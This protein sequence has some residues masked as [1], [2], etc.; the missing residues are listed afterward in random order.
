MPPSAAAFPQLNPFLRGNWV[1]LPSLSG[2]RVGDEGLVLFGVYPIA[3]IR[4][5]K[6]L[7]IFSDCSIKN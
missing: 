2:R 4:I 3:G 6:Q 7:T 1:P 5:K